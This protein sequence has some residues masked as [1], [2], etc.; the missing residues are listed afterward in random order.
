MT[1][2]GSYPTTH[3]IVFMGPLHLSELHPTALHSLYTG[4]RSRSIH[5]IAMALAPKFGGLRLGPESSKQTVHTLELCTAFLLPYFP[6]I[7]CGP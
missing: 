7:Q 2:L 5:W 1:R 3:V 4:P 6:R